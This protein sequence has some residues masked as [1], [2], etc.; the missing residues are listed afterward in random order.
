MAGDHPSNS[1][2]SPPL[3]VTKTHVPPPRQDLV[4]RP[5]L[6]AKLVAGLTHPLTL[7]S[8]PAG[9]GKTTLLNA[10]VHA[11]T[12]DFRIAWLALDEDDNDIRPSRCWCCCSTP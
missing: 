10:A 7:V 3:L 5:D 2:A 11:L 9:F 8:A 4:A 6:Q 1:G 12:G